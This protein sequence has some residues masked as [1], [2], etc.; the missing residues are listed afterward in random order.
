MC[1]HLGVSPERRHPAGVVSV[2]LALSVLDLILQHSDFVPHVVDVMV[3][4]MEKK[5]S[6][7]SRISLTRPFPY[8]TEASATASQGYKCYLILS[9]VP[10]P[11]SFSVI[12]SGARSPGTRG[13]ICHTEPSPQN[14]NH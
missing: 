4:I 12:Q 9:A 3:N 2:L 7:L 14:I 1:R 13:I 6:F 8:Y 5:C 10:D 11:I